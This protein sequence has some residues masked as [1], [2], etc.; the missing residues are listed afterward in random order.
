MDGSFDRS[1]FDCGVEEPN[2][3]LKTKAR[4]NQGKGINRNFVAISEGDQN[5]TVLGYYCISSGEVNLEILPELQ[6]KWLPKHPVPV[7][8]MGRLAR[9]LSTRGKKLGELLLVDALRRTKIL[10]K[11]IGIFA[12][13]VDT[14]NKKAENF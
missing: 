2:S 4:Q 14:K 11:Q 10:S 12:V 1:S 3:F 6:R 13:I 9:D 8:R 5:K 7:A